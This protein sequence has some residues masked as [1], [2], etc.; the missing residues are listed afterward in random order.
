MAGD[1]GRAFETRGRGCAWTV[2]CVR[3]GDPPR[4]PNRHRRDRRRRPGRRPAGRGR[5]S[6]H[7]ERIV[8]DARARRRGGI[9]LARRRPLGVA[10]P[11]GLR[12]RRAPAVGQRGAVRIALAHPG[13][14]ARHGARAAH[15]RAGEARDGRPARDGRDDRRPVRRAAAVRPVRRGRRLAGA[16]GGRDP[17]LHGLLPDRRPAGRGTGSQLAPVLHR[18]G[19]RVAVALRA[20]RWLAAGEGAPRLVQGPRV[21]RLQRRRV[22]V[23]RRPLPVARSTAAPRRTTCTRT[24]S[25]CGSS[26]GGSARTR[27]GAEAGLDLRGPAADRAAPGRAARSR[28][29]TSPIASPT[30]TTARATPIA[31]R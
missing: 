19:V 11:V 17:A 7:A 16:G 27:R 15:R 1:R 10:R 21:V 18:L 8:A 6:R 24:A 12:G 31:G 3:C 13:A 30:S 4:E 14:H 29:R 23:G 26:P 22:P 2:I 5:G 28:S 9:A 20:R 25:T